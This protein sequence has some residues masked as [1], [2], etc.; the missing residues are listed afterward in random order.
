[1]MQSGNI[2]LFQGMITQ[3]RGVVGDHSVTT[4]ASSL[5]KTACS[6]EMSTYNTVRCHNPADCSLKPLDLRKK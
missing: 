1:M 4:V 2:V 5:M 3:A 6:S